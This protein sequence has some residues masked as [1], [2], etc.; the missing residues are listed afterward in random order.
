LK[1]VGLKAKLP[2]CEFGATNIHYLGFRLFPEDIFLG[3][4]K[5]KAV[6]TQKHQEMS[7]KSDNSQAYATFSEA[8]SRTLLTLQLHFTIFKAKTQNGQNGKKAQCQ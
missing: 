2:T 1:N 4:D 5:I 8:T 3:T 6:K 7:R